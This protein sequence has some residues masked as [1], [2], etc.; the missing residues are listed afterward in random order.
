MSL[1]KSYHM[2]F[3]SDAESDE[4][5]VP[6]DSGNSTRV[7]SRVNSVKSNQKGPKVYYIKN[8]S[9]IR[10]ENVSSENGAFENDDHR[11]QP[12]NRSISLSSKNSFMRKSQVRLGYFYS[13]LK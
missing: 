9:Q 10:K 2:D 5:Y 13:L 1:S 8:N 7:N 4:N 6:S 12:D 11:N 3:K